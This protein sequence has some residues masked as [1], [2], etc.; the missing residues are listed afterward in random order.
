MTDRSEV[1]YR[2]S[3][4]TPPGATLADLLEERGIKQ[5]ELAVR[6]GVTAK[7]VNEL[8][9]GKVSITPK[10]AL[11]LERALSVPADFW[12][13]RDAHYQASLVRAQSIEELEAQ[14]DW[15]NELPLREMEKWGWISRG[16]TVAERVA[17]CFR[18][19]AVAT[20]DAWRAQYVHRVSGSAA[21]RMSSHG[22]QAEGAVSAWLRQGEIAA[23]QLQC[24]PFD[25]SCLLSAL[26]R[27][28]ELTLEADPQKF[29]PLLQRTFGDCG[30]AIVFVRAPKG[31]PAS[32]AVRWM[33]PDRALIQ[34][35]LRYKTN[36]HLW[37]TLFHECAHL[38]L[39]AKKI[40]FLEVKDMNDKD[41]DE[42][43]EFAGNWLIPQEKF[44]DFKSGA[45]SRTAIVR[46]AEKLGIAPGI[47]VGRLQ[48]EELIHWS[49][50]NDLKIRYEWS[51]EV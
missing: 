43:N 42:A 47:V 16:S 17:Q 5:N 28:R 36:D 24:K 26:E 8:I 29:I 11:L 32:G 48:K 9:L 7:F 25:K 41:E 38:M 4:V 46:F 2:P 39:H 14:C 22:S 30:V 1:I 15:L 44:S 33:A 21:W 20:V 10:T 13:T 3:T 35:S 6:L 50:H 45:I 40:L 34:L 51:D 27:A 23:L 31:C 12:L 49:Q 18:F 37:F 19:F